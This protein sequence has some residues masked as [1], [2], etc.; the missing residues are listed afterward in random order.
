MSNSPFIHL[1]RSP[2]HCYIYDVNTNRIVLV[3]EE[4]YCF[5]QEAKRKKSFMLE[6]AHKDVQT[7]IDK[8]V[9]QGFLSS[10]HPKKMKHP[11]S[12]FW[13]IIYLIILSI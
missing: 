9:Q 3:S 11:E 1:V 5:L 10:M 6:E 8:L 13:I 12:D 4:T 7:E 2:I